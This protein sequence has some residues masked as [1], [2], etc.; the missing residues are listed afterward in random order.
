MQLGLESKA[1]MSVSVPCPADKGRHYR[2][3][4]A[5]LITPQLLLLDEHTA[6][7]IRKQAI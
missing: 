7:L 4:M 2:Y 6:A 5:T 3:L 1:D